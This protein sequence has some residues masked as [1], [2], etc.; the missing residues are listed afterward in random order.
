MLLSVSPGLFSLQKIER[1]GR[2]VSKGLMVFGRGCL[3][4]S[5]VSYYGQ[6]GLLMPPWTQNEEWSMKIYV[7]YAVRSYSGQYVTFELVTTDMQAAIDYEEL[8]KSGE[9]NQEHYPRFDW[10]ELRLDTE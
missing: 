5:Q 4:A 8:L 6:R 9:G 3:F 2:A 10:E 1:Q 7:V